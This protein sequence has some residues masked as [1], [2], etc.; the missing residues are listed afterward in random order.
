MAAD[1][2]RLDVAAHASFLRVRW[3]H[4]LCRRLCFR[5]RGKADA[6]SGGDLASCV[7]VAQAALTPVGTVKIVFRT[8]EAIW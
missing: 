4:I 1:R 5:R 6:R 7:S 2:W 8:C 3:R